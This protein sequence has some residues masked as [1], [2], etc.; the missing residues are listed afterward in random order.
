MILGDQA[1]NVTSHNFTHCPMVPY[2][3]TG[4]THPTRP[5]HVFRGPY[6]RGGALPGTLMPLVVW[7]QEDPSTLMF[8]N[9]TYPRDAGVLCNP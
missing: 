2:I 5:R 8:V 4:H 9:S 7:E 3:F 1:D 6:Y